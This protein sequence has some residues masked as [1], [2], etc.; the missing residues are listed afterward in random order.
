MKEVLF[1][2]GDFEVY[3]Y[4]AMLVLGVIFLAATFVINCRRTLVS[5]KIIDRLF[6]IG[7]IA[8]VFTYLGAAF[9]D[10]LWHTISEAMVDGKFYPS[11]FHFEFDNG[12]ITFEGGII[13]GMIAFLVL[14]TFGIKN[15]TRHQLVFSDHLISGILFAH[16]LG[17]I[18]CFLSGCCY[19]KETDS[20][21]GIMYPVDYGVMAKVYPTQLYEAGFLFICFIV[22]TFVI[23]KRKTEIYFMTYGV[24]RFFLEFLRGDDRGSFLIPFL[25]PSQFMSIVMVIIGIILFIVRTKYLQNQEAHVNDEGYVHPITTYKVSRIELVSKFIKGCKCEK[26]NKRM[27]LIRI[28]NVLPLNTVEYYNDIHYDYACTN[29]PTQE[30]PTNN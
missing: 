28:N 22:F 6:I 9:F 2:I 16:C 10:A 24:F 3:S 30:I 19:G 4:S 8:G 5:E 27:K 29:C 12:G 11:M 18:G 7:S 14:L 15:E 26:C 17:R 1:K 20:I 25:S 21:F 13:T 23:N